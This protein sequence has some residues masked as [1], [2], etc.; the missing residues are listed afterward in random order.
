MIERVQT[1]K[2][3]GEC[4]DLAGAKF[5]EEGKLPG[6]FI[7]DVFKQNWI[8][9]LSAGMGAMW[10]SKRGGRP[11]GA[12]GGLIYPDINDNELVVMEAFWYV[13]PEFRGHWDSIRLYQHFEKWAIERQAKRI[14][15]VRYEA[16]SGTQ[17]EAFYERNGYR[18]IEKVF[19]KDLAWQ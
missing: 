1:L 17:L 3:L 10:V 15:M 13:L 2:A 6:Q 16:T 19:V 9:L 18:P 11:V 12:L 14:L 8:K 4:I 7:P 5:Y